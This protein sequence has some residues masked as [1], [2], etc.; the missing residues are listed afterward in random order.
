MR[1]QWRKYQNEKMVCYVTLHCILRQL[2]YPIEKIMLMYSV[3]ILAIEECHVLLAIFRAFILTGRIDV[4][5]WWGTA[6]LYYIPKSQGHKW[7]IILL[8]KFVL[9]KHET[10]VQC[11][12]LQSVAVSW[13]TMSMFTWPSGVMCMWPCCGSKT[14]PRWW[15]GTCLGSHFWNVL[16]LLFN[17]EFTTE[18][19]HHCRASCINKFMFAVSLLCKACFVGVGVYPAWIKYDL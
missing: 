14:P 1:I 5:Y 4:S 13:V 16:S 11:V 8:R 19:S 18:N 2:M 15:G 7:Y 10:K 17:R 9:F 6:F 12:Q 3:V